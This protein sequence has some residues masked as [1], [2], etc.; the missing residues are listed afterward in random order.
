MHALIAELQ[1][2]DG[3]PPRSVLVIDEA[4]MASTRITAAIF[5]HAQRSDAKIIAVGDP[6][7]LASVHAGGW[8]AALARRHPGPE[9]REVI[10]QHDPA[11]RAALEALHDSH[12]DAYLEHKHDS[13]T[14]HKDQD[15]AL[16]ALV[17]QWD[18]ARGQH[19]LAGSVMIARDNQTRAQLNRAARERLKAD[20]TLPAGGVRVAGTE[21]A[22]GDR[23][24]ARRNHR[25]A[26]IDNGT[27]ATVETVDGRT[28]RMR[29]IT[30]VGQQRE[31][32]LG[33]VARHVEH[34]YALTAHSIQGA[35]LTWAGVIGRP[36][37]FTREW[38]TPHSP[39]PANKPRCT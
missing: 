16:D 38:A 11:E 3:F 29:I 1:R 36:A 2:A 31:L 20:G 35:T 25:G 37:D 18:T 14:V 8:L 10:R 33:Y 7:Q 5:T 26:D 39:A 23:I 21:Y 27:M 34:A 6:G 24:I 9:L 32:D 17:K 19:G 15:T 30:A 4:G 28:H 12:S 22:P 13:I